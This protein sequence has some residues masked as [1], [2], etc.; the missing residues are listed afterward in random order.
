MKK[1]LISLALVTL[2]ALSGC[3]GMGA[4]QAVADD[5]KVATIKPGKTTTKDVEATFGRPSNVDYMEK[6]EQVWTY[7]HVSV[8]ALGL[9][10]FVNMTGN[11]GKE[12]SLIVRFNSKGVVKE[13]RQGQNRL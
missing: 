3:A 1:Y 4:N 2:T 11:S 10:P 6:G 12:S 5:T 8:N 9:I 7:Q 13:F